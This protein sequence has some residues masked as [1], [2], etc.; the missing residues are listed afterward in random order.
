MYTVFFVPNQLGS[1]SSHRIVK[2][3]KTNF[4]NFENPLKILNATKIKCLRKAR[5]LK[6]FRCVKQ[7]RV[8]YSNK[9]K[10]KQIIDLIRTLVIIY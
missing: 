3:V 5:L 7:F 9:E 4:Y 6:S 8:E 1:C 2:K 10:Q